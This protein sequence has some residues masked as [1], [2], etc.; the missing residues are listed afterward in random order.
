MIVVVMQSRALPGR[1]VGCDTT[2]DFVETGE[3]FVF[4][5]S[6]GRLDGI[7]GDCDVEGAYDIG[8]ATPDVDITIVDP[9]GQPVDL[10]RTVTDLEYSEAGFVGA[11]A[12]TI[13]IAETDD[14]VVRV[15]SAGRRDVRRGGRSRPERRGRLTAGRRRCGRNSRTAAGWWTHSARRAA[16]PGD[17]CRAAVGARCRRSHRRRSHRGRPRRALRCTASRSA[18]RRTRSRLRRTT[19]NSR[20]SRS[21]RSRRS[22]HSRNSRN[23]RNS[24]SR[25]ASRRS[26]HSRNSRNSRS[27]R[28]SRRT[29]HSR[30]SRSR[31]ST[32]S[33]NSRSR[34]N[35]HKSRNSRSR[36]ST[37]SRSQRRVRHRSPVSPRSRVKPAGGRH[38]H[39]PPRLRFRRIRR[40]AHNRSDWAQQGSETEAGS[41]DTAPPDDEVRARLR[42]ELDSG[43]A[44]TEERPPPPPPS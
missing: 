34:H 42:D 16:L 41:A 29:T 38:L 14:H 20:N 27:R 32:H 13:D 39:R 28:A 17:G 18:H 8:S 1:P 12:F 19:G 11:A 25:R 3:Y 7:R 35:S 44:R 36:R 6:A 21:R 22:T 24:R 9:D 37:H 4:I 40:P 43:A 26:T 10:D 31:R 33:R 2:L 30:S 23:S 15:E 5:E